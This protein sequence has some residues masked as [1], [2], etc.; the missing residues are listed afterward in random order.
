MESG[1]AKE[2]VIFAIKE[3]VKSCTFGEMIA[4]DYPMFDIE[5]V[6]LHNTVKIS[7]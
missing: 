2:I 5:Y 1:D 4:E 3:I 7:R 6:F